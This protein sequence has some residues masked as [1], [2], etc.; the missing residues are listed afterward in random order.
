MSGM[1]VTDAR[2]KPLSFSDKIT[3]IPCRVIIM[4]A[5]GLDGS[6]KGLNG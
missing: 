5:S 1:T 6:P 3:D 2:R 4:R